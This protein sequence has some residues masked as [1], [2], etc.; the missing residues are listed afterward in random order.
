MAKVIS[1][2]ESKGIATNKDTGTKVP[3][4]NY[5]FWLTSG[6]RIY[7]VEQVLAGEGK[8]TYVK[9]KKQEYDQLCKDDPKM[10]FGKEVHFLTEM[11]KLVAIQVK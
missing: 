10:L 6:D 3:Y 4:D 8:P 9:I 1:I 5:V 2:I 7:S 11:G